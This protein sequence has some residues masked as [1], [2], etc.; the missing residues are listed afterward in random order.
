MI[1]RTLALAL[2]AAQP[3]G[4]TTALSG[5]TVEAAPTTPQVARAY[6]EQMAGAPPRAISLATWQ[7]P[8]CLE[9]QNLEAE[10]AGLLAARIA[11]RAEQVGV[12]VRTED[13]RPN[14]SI[15]A[16][17]DG[18]RTATTL[19][20]EHLTAFRASPN[21]T[22]GDRDALRR[23]AEDDAPVRWWTIAAQYDTHTRDYAEPLWRTGVSRLDT[24]AY[25]TMN[26]TLV[27]A[28]VRTIV[29]ID[30]SRTGAVSIEALG[31][32]IAMVTLAEIKP[33]AEPR[34]YP[35][36][37]SLWRQHAVD[38]GMSTWDERYLRAL[39]CAEL[40]QPG[41]GPPIFS[42][43]QRSD[44]ARRMAG[45]QKPGRVEATGVCRRWGS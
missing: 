2:L 41:S 18:R 27:R 10:A 9:T 32:Y 23:F 35:T 26:Q 4:E 44:I 30:A 42:R 16:T 12:T 28:M 25:T 39:Y 40:R 43:Y 34:A 31:D 5:V 19:V 24:P 17:A 6:V 29:V 7:T 36:V 13:C 1:G 21:D 11:A 8:I 15:L 38:G 3:Q 20:A 33:T 14:V 45:P 22:Q 37:L